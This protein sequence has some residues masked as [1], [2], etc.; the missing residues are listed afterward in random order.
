MNLFA[1]ERKSRKKE[2]SHLQAQ[3]SEKDPIIEQMKRT[4]EEDKLQLIQ[5]W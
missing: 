4:Y 1:K 5:K 2:M 3:I